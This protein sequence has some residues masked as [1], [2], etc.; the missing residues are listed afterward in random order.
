MTDDELVEQGMAIFRGIVGRD[1]R[2]LCA[3]RIARDRYCPRPTSGRHGAILCAE[4]KRE[5]QE[6]DERLMAGYEQTPSEFGGE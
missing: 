5:A 4:H 3:K 6:Q 2:G 1:S